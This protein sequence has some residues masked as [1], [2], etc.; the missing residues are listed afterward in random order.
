MAG[1]GSYL[2]SAVLTVSVTGSLDK[3]VLDKDN[4]DESGESCAC[5]I[6][7]VDDKCCVCGGVFAWSVTA[8]LISP[9]LTG[10]LDEEVSDKDNVDESGEGCAC[11]VEA[12]DAV[13]WSWLAG[14][15][16]EPDESEEGCVCGSVFTGSLTG[17]GLDMEELMS[18][19]LTVSFDE[20]EIVAFPFC[21]GKRT[22]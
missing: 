7:P 15:G 11:T 3:G 10:S 14:G 20:G 12:V 6:E 22:E 21:L 9:S 4:A 1:S 2:I 19:S 5:M 13:G 16:R 17:S 8:D 18:A